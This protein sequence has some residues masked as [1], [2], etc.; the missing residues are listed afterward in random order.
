MHDITKERELEHL[1]DEFFST[2]SH[3]LRTPLF[4]IQGFAQLM[5]EEGDKLDVA[6]RAEFLT[7]I[8]RQALQLSE[9]V[10]NLLDMARLDE[11]KLDLL[12]QPVVIDDLIHQTL[13]KLQG[14][15]HQQ[16]VALISNLGSMLPTVIG[17]RERLEQVLTNLIGNAI[18]FS[19]AG[20]EV[21][22]SAITNE[23]EIQIAVKDN[24]VGIPPQELEQIFTR[25]YQAESRSKHS[26]K[27]SGLGLHIAQKIVEAHKG[28]IW[29]ESE[30][31]QG[32]T[33]YFTLPL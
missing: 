8:Q 32:S 4:S 14:F 20:G 11:G 25:Y 6:T 2:V 18:K 27:G 21:V 17:D 15:A 30:V 7:T 33:F 16:Q 5:V 28:R 19:E 13:L 29:A 24:G 1:K 10:N 23:H 31:G 26:A 12:S 9:M 22:V 3:E